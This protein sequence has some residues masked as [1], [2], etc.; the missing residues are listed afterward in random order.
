[1]NVNVH[2]QGPK[3]WSLGLS[4][5]LGSMPAEKCITLLECKLAA[6]GLSLEHDIVCICTDSATHKKFELLQSSCSCL[7]KM[8]AELGCKYIE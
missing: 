6:F 5:V 1:M 3:F 4:E 7:I 8:R 2:E